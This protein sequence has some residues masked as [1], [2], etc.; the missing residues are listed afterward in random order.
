MIGRMKM[1]NCRRG[2]FSV[3]ASFAVII[4]LTMSLIFYTFI[5]SISSSLH[6]LESRQKTV[7]LIVFSNEIVRKEGAYKSNTET[8][9]NLISI[10]DLDS[11][12]IKLTSLNN[13]EYG[14]SYIEWKLSSKN[15][16]VVRNF[17]KQFHAA[18]NDEIFCI[19]RLVL[20][21][22]FNWHK[23]EEGILR[24]CIK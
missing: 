22:D 7:S 4:I 12:A 18:D 5:Q 11:F 10:S 15:G 3:D 21:N 6:N 9:S 23:Y 17:T 14:F 13:S 20:I 19:N 2:L 24:V 8:I 16:S 1:K